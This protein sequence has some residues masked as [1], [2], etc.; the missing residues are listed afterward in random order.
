VDAGR[1]QSDPFLTAELN[2]DVSIAGQQGPDG[3]RPDMIPRIKLP[4]LSMIIGAICE[5]RE[6]TV[7]LQGCSP[8]EGIR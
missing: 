1:I 5:I 4:A 3:F 8:Q 6:G 7:A 2:Y